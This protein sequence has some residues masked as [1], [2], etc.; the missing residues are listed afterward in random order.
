M[1]RSIFRA[2][3]RNRYA[4]PIGGVFIIL[5]LVGFFTVASFCLNTTKNLL[6]N[7]ARKK[8]FERMLLPV[9]IFDPVPFENPVNIDNAS[10][11]QYSIWSTA[12][13]EKR[14]QY[15]YDDA[16][17]M[18][19][20]ASD[21]DVAA[22]Q[23]F[24]PD[25]RLEHRSFGDLQDSYLYEE[26]IRSYHVPIIT[27]TGFATPRVE[28]INKMSGDTIELRMGYVPP[29]T[30]LDLDENNNLG[31]PEPEKYMIYELRKN[32][33]G[34]YL[35]AVK[36]VPGAG[37]PGAN[38]FQPPMELP[39]EDL[40]ISEMVPE[41]AGNAGSSS[42]SSAPEGDGSSDEGS[43]S[44]GEG[45]EEPGED[46]GEGEGEEETPEGEEDPSS[47]EPPPEMQG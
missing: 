8:E 24:G 13:G 22:Q 18:I 11:L 17:M 6:D 33:S 28:E 20:P 39:G 38:D 42:V 12:I 7:S 46:E 26:E 36:D 14:S 3:R 25:V 34:W 35:Y 9:V 47:E 5:C 30:I 15:E 43:S 27:I 4:A 1:N 32:R 19:I 31:D 45:E 23:L 16:G 10:L 37:L 21:I 41:M 2:G 29:S 40:S 44:D